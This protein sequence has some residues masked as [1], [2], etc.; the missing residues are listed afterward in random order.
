[1][2]KFMGQ[3]MLRIS[4]NQKN[5][6]RREVTFKP[7]IPPH[8]SIVTIGVSCFSVLLVRLVECAD[9]FAEPNF[10]KVRP[11][12]EYFYAFHFTSSAEKGTSQCSQQY[13]L[14]SG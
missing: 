14:Q 10:P 1:M 13:R 7:Y 5:M 9:S 8:T 4:P 6:V 2:A 11:Q 12:A 3:S